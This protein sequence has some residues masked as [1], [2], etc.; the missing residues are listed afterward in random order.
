MTLA[1][2]VRTN[3][4]QSKMSRAQLAA[5]L[6]VAEVLVAAVEEPQ[7]ATEQAIAFFSNAFGVKPDVFTGK[8]PRGP[9]EEE[10]RAKKAAEEAERAAGEEERKAREAA[11]EAA[12]A[13]YPLIRRFLLDKSRCA[14]PDVVRRLFAAE[15]FSLAERNVVLYISTTAL[16]NFCDSNTSNFAFDT[17]LFKHHGSLLKKF[18]TEVAGRGLPADESEELLA[19]A[20]GDIFRCEQIENIAIL[21]LE[22]FAAELE[23]RLAKGTV[24]FGQDI[25]P[26]FTW[27]LDEALMRIAVKGK[28][29]KLLHEIR[30]LDVRGR[31]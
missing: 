17:Y 29:G 25:D 2:M 6:G 18:E 30:L 12:A 31:G 26:N 21:V 16:Y 1:E 14:N 20:R 7:E 23:A 3:R 9:T 4:E 24:D 13:K 28:A 5:K 8:A 27:E 19:M 22:D 11:A 10:M 15:P